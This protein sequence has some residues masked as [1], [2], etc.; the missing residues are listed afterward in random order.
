V[1]VI[2]GRWLLAAATVTWTDWQMHH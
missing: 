1:L 2:V